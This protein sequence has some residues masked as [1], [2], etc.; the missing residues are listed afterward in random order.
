MCGCEKNIKTFENG[1]N[2]DEKDV[3]L[4]DI[5]DL[6]GTIVEKDLTEEAL[7]NWANTYEWYDLMD[8]SEDFPIGQID[9]VEDAII[10]IQGLDNEGD[11]TV[12]KKDLVDSKFENGGVIESFRRFTE[13]DFN[14][15]TYDDFEGRWSGFVWEI[16]HNNS[17]KTLGKFN[18]KK[19]TLFILG[20][21]DLTNPLVKWLQQNSFVSSDEYHKLENG[22][23][24]GKSKLYVDNKEPMFSKG[25]VIYVKL[26]GALKKGQI[27][28]EAKTEKLKI[29]ND[30]GYK[31]TYPIELDNGDFLGINE[32]ELLNE[33]GEFYQY[34]MGGKIS[35][36]KNWI[37][38][39]LSGGKNKGALRRT[40]MRKGLLR[41]EDEKLSMTDLHKLEKV[42]GKTARRAYLAETLRK[43]DNGGGVN[44]F[45]DSTEKAKK[46]IN[47]LIEKGYSI[48]SYSTN[49]Q[50]SAFG[51]GNNVIFATQGS[52]RPNKNTLEFAIAYFYENDE[53]G[54][55]QIDESLLD[56]IADGFS[57]FKVTLYTNAGVDLH[58]KYKGNY[59]NIEVIK[60][61]F[62]T[63]N[64]TEIISELDSTINKINSTYD[65][66]T[67]SKMYSSN[68]IQV[69]SPY[70][71]TLSAIKRNEFNGNGLME[72]YG[73]TSS[74][75][76]YSNKA[77]FDNGG[78]IEEYNPEN[79]LFKNS[80]ETDNK[81]EVYIEFLNKDK[82]YNKDIKS[83]KSYNQA[84]EWARENFERFDP[85]M[86]KYYANG[87]EVY[88]YKV[89]DVVYNKQHNTI[90]IVRDIFDRND[91]RTDA[92]GVVYMSDL[93]I[94]DKNN[95]KHKAADIAPSTKKELGNKY[96]NGG[97]VGGRGW[98]KFKK[99]EKISS[100]KDVKIGEIYLEHSNQF[101]SNNIIIITSGDTTGLN[102]DIVYASFVR[103]NNLKNIEETFAIW[104]HDLERKIDL[105]KI[106]G[107]KYEFGGNVDLDIYPDEDLRYTNRKI[108]KSQETLVREN[109]Y[110]G[111]IQEYILK[112]IIGKEPE[113]PTQI[114]G[115]LKLTK[116]FLRPYYKI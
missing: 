104:G 22:G 11:Y 102:R 50:D 83:F 93:E 99:G 34:K 12:V 68:R 108:K 56:S 94:Y 8:V 44:S 7:I 92:D 96:E 13:G 6:D 27:Y 111:E 29:G 71:N 9:N 53:S 114:V 98:G 47:F 113:Y 14:R 77:Y 74:Y 15:L 36:N 73:N 58:Y 3:V 45:N 35:K 51:E 84:V 101:N 90:G 42:G 23:G 91:L 89:G 18:P 103:P 16:K 65:G 109:I 19:N 75:V 60:V 95:P 24:I 79:D 85:D 70:F 40:A 37:A 61:P 63:F 72:K 26:H 86:I 10:A 78:D 49:N 25:D 4:Y 5:V 115:S 88:N 76:L 31:H 54:V 97:E 48:D 80:I 1:G 87:G 21:K 38:N 20:K 57:N 69:V 100:L 17:S 39:A 62:D 112:A 33:K 106:K 41:N 81:D 66:V 28:R 107:R 82:G 116:C 43:F 110:N 46:E 64:N 105:Y 55:M 2:I 32:I 52:K 67:A 59:K 30:F